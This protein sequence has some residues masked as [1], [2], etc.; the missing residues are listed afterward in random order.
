MFRVGGAGVSLVDAVRPLMASVSEH[1]V[2]TF[3]CRIVGTER[4]NNNKIQQRVDDG[5]GR[6]REQLKPS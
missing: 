5:M 6:R 2:A 3:F 1:S 4:G